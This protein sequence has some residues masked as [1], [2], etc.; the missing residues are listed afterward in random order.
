M[1]VSSMEHTKI[2]GNEDD[3]LEMTGVYGEGITSVNKSYS[4]VTWA[5]ESTKVFGKSAI[6]QYK[7]EQ[8]AK[9]NVTSSS[10]EVMPQAG[11]RNNSNVTLIERP[12]HQNETVVGNKTKYFQTE[13]DEMELTGMNHD[14]SMMQ[15]QD[16]SILACSDD[17]HMVS[18][19]NKL[20]SQE[21]KINSKMF[22]A[23]LLSGGVSK[24]N[25][26]M[27]VCR[28]ED[29]VDITEKV[30]G[31][32]FLKGLM[33]QTELPTQDG[34]AGEINSLKNK[35]ALLSESMDLTTC[36][37]E[38]PTISD[39]CQNT[40]TVASKID[41]KEF[42]SN[43]MGQSK[44]SQIMEAPQGK[45]DTQMFLKNFMAE[46]NIEKP[47]DTTER[48]RIFDSAEENVKSEMQFD[49]NLFLRNIVQEKTDD[50]RDCCDGPESSETL[51]PDDSNFRKERKGLSDI[52]HTYS[53][54]EEI[55][56]NHT[57]YFNQNNQL[58][59]DDGC[60]ENTE[61][62]G[63]ILNSTV[64]NVTKSGNKTVCFNL[65]HTVH[66]VDKVVDSDQEHLE[67]VIAEAQ[68]REQNKT[69]HFAN[70]SCL[71]EETACTGQL[72]AEAEAKVIGQNKTVYFTSDSC[73]MEETACTGQLVSQADAIQKEQNQTQHFANESCLMEETACTGK[74]V[75]EME[76]EQNK[77]HHIAEESCV[78]EEAVS[79]D[80]SIS[81]AEAA[82]KNQA[83]NTQHFANESCFMEETGC[84]GRFITGANILG[85]EQNKTL[86]FANKSCFME[87]TTCVG[88]LLGSGQ[89]TTDNENII[90]GGCVEGIG[91]LGNQ[92]KDKVIDHKTT[93]SPGAL[94]VVQKEKLED[95]SSLP[96][97]SGN[98]SGIGSDI[99]KTVLFEES[100]MEETCMTGILRQKINNL[101]QVSVEAKTGVKNQQESIYIQ[102]GTKEK[103]SFEK[104]KIFSDM[105]QTSGGFA[106]EETVC[107]G[108]LVRDQNQ[109]S[110]IE[111]EH[112]DKKPSNIEK[113]DPSEKATIFT[114]LNKTG[115][116]AMNE[117]LFESTQSEKVSTEMRKII[118]EAGQATGGGPIEETVCVGGLM[119]GEKHIQEEVTN[120]SVGIGIHNMETVAN[121]MEEFVCNNDPDIDDNL[122][123]EHL[124]Q[125]PNKTERTLLF[126]A[127]NKTAG[128]LDE[129]SCIG[130]IMSAVQLNTN[131]EELPFEVPGGVV[132]NKTII[133]SNMDK[134]AVGLMEETECIGKLMVTSLPLPAEK[135]ISENTCKE[136]D[137]HEHMLGTGGAVQQTKDVHL[138]ENQD[139][140]ST[141]ERE[142]EF[143][144]QDSSIS[145]DDLYTTKERVSDCN[146]QMDNINSPTY[147]QSPGISMQALSGQDNSKAAAKPLMKL[148]KRLQRISMGPVIHAADDTCHQI[149]AMDQKLDS[150]VE[151][152]MLA[153]TKTGEKEVIKES[154]TG[155]GD[156]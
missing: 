50:N 111:T 119:E 142:I 130:G 19:N 60:L 73:L 77:T 61:C 151:E 139:L 117:T 94:A 134:T 127:M 28:T 57:I 81:K 55:E 101:N 67:E 29:T 45:V 102:Q 27:V 85:N 143:V 89:L 138:Q 152:D 121:K 36:I 96:S 79:S 109:V 49:A 72:M 9:L 70:D 144:S 122:D 74:L 145:K 116:V 149:E 140:T 69:V 40:Q 115:A 128:L 131:M 98:I 2:F 80:K 150:A 11:C 124:Q 64:N 137:V 107:V 118:P 56:D 108:G 7:N 34:R 95:A 6:E 99:N 8:Q 4:N 5:N 43:L 141:I 129:T 92:N 24:Q 59:N 12:D 155:M 31:K 66:L 26:D 136:D 16:M 18:G 54:P 51:R 15:K 156:K 38:S 147:P 46:P 68:T 17:L 123:N 133:Y 84:T 58:N 103:E 125:K 39:K 112:Y 88:K 86:H 113:Q 22:L 76:A 120:N 37:A 106:M 13:D 90:G 52:T 93:P 42:L 3:Q 33:G 78:M 41:S 53:G 48:N 100:P 75:A 97:M 132:Q 62:I 35:T 44:E 25:A 14:F 126:G 135:V 23:G 30:D 20:L 114:E 65:E 21:E 104:T 87:E 148:K 83:D 1:P 110:D 82:Q 32:S 63:G 47:A 91:T 146:N 154:V 153:Q 105:N 71:M 10:G